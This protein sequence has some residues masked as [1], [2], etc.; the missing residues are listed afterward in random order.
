[1]IS[2]Q[3]VCC[4]LLF[5]DL[6]PRVVKGSVTGNIWRHS[7]YKPTRWAGE[8]S[9]FNCRS[10]NK[11]L[12]ASSGTVQGN[13]LRCI[14]SLS[15]TY[16]SLSY[17]SHERLRGAPPALVFL[18]LPFRLL[19]MWSCCIDY[20]LHLL[21]V[22]SVFFSP[23]YCELLPLLCVIFPIHTQPISMS[24]SKCSLLR[25]RPKVFLQTDS[26]LMVFSSINGRLS[27]DSA[28]LTAA[29]LWF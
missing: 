3:Y 6:Q 21:C 14:Y 4:V 11:W 13:L 23:F 26:L 19:H 16:L 9:A 7:D 28:G 20:S 2:V 25:S 10:R 12:P 24:H 1:M 29:A 22:C 27:A 8:F 18:A 15:L 17:L 5:F